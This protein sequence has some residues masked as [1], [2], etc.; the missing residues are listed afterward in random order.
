MDS[1]SAATV[2]PLT[3]EEFERLPEEDEFR[4]EL[5][6]GRVVREARPGA[7]HCD[8]AGRIYYALETFVRERDAGKVVYEG[9]FVLES[10]P[11]TVRGP[12]V[13]FIAASRLASGRSSRRMWDLAPDLAVEVL[14]PSN[15]PS[16]ILEKVAEYLRVGVRLIW[17]VD[18]E[19]DRLTVYDTL[20]NVG[21]LSA[22]DALEADDVLPGFRLEL[23]SVFA[24]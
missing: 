15:L 1:K 24:D 21:V 7:R 8:V 23:E 4:L 22:E 14:S 6:R 18:P 11:P 20:G 16:R 19:R 3:L 9:G 13:A 5:V 17:V 2:E 12:D 10:D